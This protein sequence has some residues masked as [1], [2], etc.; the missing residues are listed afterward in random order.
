VDHSK[1]KAL[2]GPILWL[3]TPHFAVRLADINRQLHPI[4]I[5]VSDNIHS[6]TLASTAGVFSSP[7]I[8]NGHSPALSRSTYFFSSSEFNIACI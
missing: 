4:N 2:I 6:G 1:L 5:I 7:L 3:I 8:P